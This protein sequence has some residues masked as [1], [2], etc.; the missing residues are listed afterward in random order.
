[1]NLLRVDLLVAGLGFL[2][3]F[4][5]TSAPVPESSRTGEI[6]EVKVGE[7]L[8]PKVSHAKTGDEVRWVNTTNSPVHISL[9]KALN[10]RL[11]C[12]KGFVSNEG[13]EFVG[14]PNPENI[15][16]AT[17]NSN[18]FASLCFSESGIYDYTVKGTELEGTV[19]VK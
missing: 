9:K 8:T 14:S 13:F 6:T 2:V 19:M 10:E 4:A 18:D 5:C 15:L 3:A 17:V 7:V 1:M 11:S 16:G 12:L